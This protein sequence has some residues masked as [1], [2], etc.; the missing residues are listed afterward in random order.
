MGVA[1]RFHQVNLPSHY[2]MLLVCKVQEDEW[3]EVT[4]HLR[5]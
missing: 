2:L 5:D 1:G 4:S 3:H